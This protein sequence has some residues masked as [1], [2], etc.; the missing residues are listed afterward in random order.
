MKNTTL[1]ALLA[2]LLPVWAHAAP[3]Y[4]IDHMEPPLWWTGMHNSKLQ[5]MV[6]GPQIADLEPTLAYPG[7][8]IASVARVANRN[9][10]F[11]DLEIAPDAAPG[12]LDLAFGRGSRALHYGYQ[13]LARSPGSA[14]R[15]GF[16]SGDAIYEVM[17]DRYANANPA[18]D[19]APD[20]AE[21]A[22]R[23]DGSGRHGGDLQGIAD[24]L[25][26]IAGM[27][28]TTVWPTPLLESNMPA[29]S[30]HGYASTNHYRIDP[31]YGSNEEYRSFV[32]QARAKGLGVIQDV[33][34]NHIGSKHWWMQDMPTPDWLTYQGKFVPTEHHRVAVQ[35]PYASAEDRRN[36][37]AGW[38]VEDMP[39]L[40]Q[41]NPYVAT[42]LIQNNIWW[43]E[44]AGLSGLRV[45]TYGYS[46]TSFLSRWS[47]S[48]MAE[49]PKLNLVGE[50]WSP[51]IPVVAFW[52]EGKRN[53]NGYVSH[54]PSMMDFPLTYTM[55]RALAAQEGGEQSLTNLYET[56][57]QDYLY[58]NA[59]NLVLFEG[60]HDVSRIYSELNA[61]DGL[62]RMAMAFVATAPRIPQF[63]AG[64]EVQM[65]STTKG[66]DDASY[67]HDFPGG[68]PGDA[69][70]A[71]TGA[72]LSAQ[73]AAAQAYVKKLLNWRKGASVIHH[74]KMMHY[75]PEQN[76]YV[77]FRYDGA[78]KVMVAFNKN[79]TDTVLKTARFH[80]MLAGVRAGVDVATGKRLSLDGEVTLPARSA[81]ILEIEQ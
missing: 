36:F 40:N 71:F 23:A 16:G 55:R 35:D 68:W 42:Y 32:A 17:P 49:Y 33:V 44:Y 65:T 54:M 64:T 10:L 69:V 41:A 13:L 11:I 6:H 21:R 78:R 19:N 61:D 8:R 70:N 72:G 47:G 43:I 81:L 31:R 50:E 30:Y 2:S 18:N 26:Y 63:Y 80:E 14:Q 74:G 53:F 38:F 39:D 56:L 52:Q 48:V 27:G 51:L 25:D 22:N 59:G 66:R 62:F 1:A 73:Q 79:S 29:Y 20:M 12:K 75:G 45:D 57:S 4:R 9:Y 58:P 7:V 46:D 37:T 28:F 5:L 67:R 60:N 77:Y 3:D 24:H 15:V 76:T 34:L